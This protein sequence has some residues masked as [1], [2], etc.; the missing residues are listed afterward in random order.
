MRSS[1]QIRWGKQRTHPSSVF[2]EGV[3]P[4]GRGERCGKTKRCAGSPAAADPES[5]DHGAGYLQA[6]PAAPL[7]GCVHRVSVTGTDT[8]RGPPPHFNVTC[9]ILR[10]RESFGFG[11]CCL[12]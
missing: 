11:V 3:G 1:F 12:L 6:A 9:Q 8:V 2:L 4:Q 7:W 5:Q 10:E